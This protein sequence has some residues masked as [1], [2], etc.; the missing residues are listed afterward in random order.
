MEKKELRNQPCYDADGNFIGW[1]SRSIAVAVFIFRKKEGKLQV[2]TEIRG[3]GAA[4]YVGMRC[5]VCGY[6]DFNENLAEASVRE[7]QQ[8][9]GIILNPQ[10]LQFVG[11]NDDPSE[12]RQN[13]TVRYYY[14]CDGEDFDL[15]MAVGG[16]KDEVEKVEWLDV[17]NLPNDFCFNHRERI[18]EISNLI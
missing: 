8:E 10:K 6:L 9:C 1:F 14:V 11:I 13:V 3:K 15:E 2:L 4:D 5:C 12:N 7:S 16:E 18:L 17:D